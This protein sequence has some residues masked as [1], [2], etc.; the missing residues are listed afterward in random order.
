[1][2]LVYNLSSTPLLRGPSG[3][4]RRFKLVALGFEFNSLTKAITELGI[5]ST[6]HNSVSF[7]MACAQ[8]KEKTFEALS[9][10]QLVFCVA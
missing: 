4:V 9:G 5:I 6:H 1:M 8:W 2:L 3:L 10:S 7:Q